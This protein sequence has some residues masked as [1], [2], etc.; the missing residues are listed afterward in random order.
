MLIDAV[1]LLSWVYFCEEWTFIQFANSLVCVFQ[2]LVLNKRNIYFM[3]VL[4]FGNMY[5]FA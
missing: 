4:K 5:H 3:F 1:G 2:N